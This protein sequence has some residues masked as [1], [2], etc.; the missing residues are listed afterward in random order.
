MIIF[1]LP[2][3]KREKMSKID[4]IFNSFVSNNLFKNK[5]VIQSKYTP[6]NIPHRNEQIEQVASIL[7]PSLRGERAS[8][9]FIYGN[10]GT[11]K[12]LS[13]QHVT[14]KILQKAKEMGK[15][16]LKVIYINCKMKKVSDTEYRIIAELIKELGGKV[17]DTGLPTGQVYSKFTELID[18]KKQVVLIV[19]DEIDQ[20][21]EKI[22][23][24]F[25]YTLIRMN[26]ELKN[27]QIS[28]IGISNDATFMDN[29]DPRAKSSL[30]EEELIFSPYNALQLQDILKERAESAF[31]E[32]VLEEGVIQKCAAFAAR[33]DGDARRALDLL[34]VAGEIAEREKSGKIRLTHIDAANEKIERDKMIDIISTQPKQFQLVLYAIMK[35][36]SDKNVGKFFTGDVFNIYQEMCNRTKSEILT[37]RRVSDILAEYDMLGVINADVIS[38]GRRGR[39]REIKLML[40][41]A[42][43][44]KARE[45]LEE[46]LGI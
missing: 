12:T 23:D 1:G 16:N 45:I 30:S 24:S 33:V 35:L 21:V 42:I 6:S 43:K 34:R 38:K 22:S 3:N 40:S 26:S 25:I 4:D 17:A 41:P 18:N 37:Q 27:A 32:G 39:T 9:L 29:L 46:G 19:L 14:D 31:K 44:E 20:A 28:I 15:D 36:S 2:V 13:I 7:A 11:G 5:E 8:N 10:P